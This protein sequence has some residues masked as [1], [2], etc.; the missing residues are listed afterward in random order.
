MR[1]PALMTRAARACVDPRRRRMHVSIIS[2]MLI[3]HLATHYATYVPAIREVVGSFPYFRLHALHEA[4]FLLIIAYAAVALGLRGGLWAIGITAV[5]S[6]PF[7][8]TP[9]IFG[10]EPRPGEIAELTTQVAVILLMGLLITMLVHLDRLRRQAEDRSQMEREVAQ[11]RANFLSMAAHE[12]RTPLTAV[13]GFAELLQSGRASERQQR[14]WVG[15]IA[16]QTTRMR[17]LV[18]DL[19]SLS[20]TEST[21]I[22]PERLHALELA[23]DAL[24]AIGP[25][26]PTH[27]IA[28]D[29]P[30]DL[31]PV[32][33]DRLRA[34]QVL[35]NLLSNA[36]KYSPQGGVVRLS[37]GL[38]EDGHARIS[39][40][41]PGM[42]ISAEDQERLFG[43]FFR[44]PD[45][46]ASGIPGT[47]LG[48]YI[49]KRLVEAMGGQLGLQSTPGRGSKFS[50]TLPVWNEA[51]AQASAP[52]APAA[53]AA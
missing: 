13:S 47:G 16:E 38:A 37:A 45:A 25:V 15:T 28:V 23:G 40:A 44:A 52:D 1:F 35:V 7:I 50:F 49:T 36:I 51:L 20:R 53:P 33:A 34:S 26:P 21:A 42:G 14:D 27:H 41:D 10:R 30:P 8:L 18:D 3:L 11:T 2:V 6:V 29:I 4:E 9:V 31:T 39:V 43:T 17:A 5:T 24:T 46:V 22:N 32:A 12:L 48:L 19:L